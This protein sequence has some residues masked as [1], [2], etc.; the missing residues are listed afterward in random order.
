MSGDRNFD[1]LAHRFQR[2]I[3]DR[4]KGDIRLTVLE[5]DLRETIPHLFVPVSDR[6]PMKVLDAG[7]GLG[8]FSRILAAAGHEILLCDIS[9]KML[10]MA[11]AESDKAGLS[12]KISFLNRSIQDVCSERSGQFDLVLCHA[13]LE[14]VSEPEVLLQH[15]VNALAPE[16]WMSLTF[17]NRN[18][19]IIKNLLRGNF[20]KAAQEEYRGYRG[21]LTPT[22]PLAPES[23]YRWVDAL[24]LTIQSHSGI[25]CFHDYLLDPLLR[26]SSPDNQL[27][28]ELRFS[29]QEP[30][31]SMARYIHLLLSAC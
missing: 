2:N 14:W 12:E 21:S 22:Y 9:S 27:E 6:K 13:V 20:A 28:L 30:F 3:Y 8:Q 1:D 31:R 15:L 5:R 16:G 10:D 11:K 17:Y 7:G 19:I 4:L 18:S 29:R 23:V 25:R 26:Q 24:P